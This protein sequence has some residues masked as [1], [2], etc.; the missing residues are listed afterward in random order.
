MGL[1]GDN[2][3]PCQDAA[4]DPDGGGLAGRWWRGWDAVSSVPVQTLTGTQCFPVIGEQRIW[5]HRCRHRGL[6]RCDCGD[7]VWRSVCVT[8][9]A[10]QEATV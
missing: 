8:K 6:L 2:C 1:I 9:V 10:A 7:V 4:N 3:K 5:L